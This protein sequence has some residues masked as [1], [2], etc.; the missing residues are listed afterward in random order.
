MH[1]RSITDDILHPIFGLKN[2]AVLTCTYNLCFEQNKNNITIF[3][4]KIIIFTALKNHSILYRR[5][6]VMLMPIPQD[7]SVCLKQ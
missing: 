2:E 3:R 7:L 1:S 4:L 5:V 6:I